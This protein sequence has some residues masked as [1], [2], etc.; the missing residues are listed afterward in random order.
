ML[1]TSSKE[2]AYRKKLLTQFAYEKQ[3]CW[4]ADKICLGESQFALSAKKLLIC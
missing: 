3:I 2:F 4:I 1:L